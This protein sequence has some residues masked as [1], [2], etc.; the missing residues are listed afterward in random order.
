MAPCKFTID[1]LPDLRGSEK[2]IKQLLDFRSTK[3]L[4]KKKATKSNFLKEIYNY[5]IIHLN[6]HA[7]LDAVTKEPWIAFRDKKMSLKEMYGIE[8]QASLVV[9]DACKTNDGTLALGE[10][11]INLSRGF[12]Y[13]GT[14]SV[15]A[16]LWNV[17]E[18]SGNTI[19]KLFY[20]NLQR[21]ETKSKALQLAKVDYLKSHDKTK[22]L[23]YYWGAFTLT[24]NTESIKLQVNNYMNLL[25]SIGIAFLLFIIFLQIKKKWTTQ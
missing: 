20:K 2:S 12:F 1:N 24:G 10:G 17:N 9:L 13:N 16:S 11:I 5:E 4:L 3:S 23:P 15:L 7:G 14:Q 22:I 18:Q 25:I 8:N 21:G 19:L 6:T